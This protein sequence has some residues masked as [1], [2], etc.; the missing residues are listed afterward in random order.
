MEWRRQGQPYLRSHVPT[1]DARATSVYVTEN[2][3]VKAA[4][5]FA[6]GAHGVTGFYP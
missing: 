6:G 2:L 1:L 3:D 5:S 4:R